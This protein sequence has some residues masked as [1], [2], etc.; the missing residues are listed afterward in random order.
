MTLPIYHYHPTTGEYLGSSLA[1][2]DPLQPDAFLIPHGATPDAPPTA[3]EHEI[4]VRLD[5]SWLIQPDWRDVPL[6]HTADG[7]PVS[8]APLGQTPDELTATPLPRPSAAHIWQDDCWSFDPERQTALLAELQASL[9]Q[10]VDAAA[11]AARLAVAGDALR[12]IEYQRAEGEAQA[13]R[14]AR[15]SGTVPP[16]VASWADAKGWTARRAADDILAE[17]ARW[18]ATL[19]ATRDRRLKGKEEVRAATDVATAQATAEAVITALR[20]DTQSTV[21]ISA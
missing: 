5:G 20:M 12:V 13:Y 8:Q 3:G 2:P 11:D 18:N 9:C 6:Y 21:S 16:A 4:A 7:S 14:D 19:Y 15:Y 1:D 17:A 10:S